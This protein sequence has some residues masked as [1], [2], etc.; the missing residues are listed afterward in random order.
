MAEKVNQHFPFGFDGAKDDPV[1]YAKLKELTSPA[2]RP[3]STAA[4]D[5]FPP[6]ESA[7]R[8]A[9]ARRPGFHPSRSPAWTRT[10]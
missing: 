7:G 4:R 1:V 9:Q 10:S 3:A 6:P 8:L 5:Y 2:A